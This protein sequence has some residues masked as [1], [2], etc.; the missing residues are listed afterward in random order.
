[1]KRKIRTKPESK[2][3]CIKCGEEFDEEPEEYLCK[4]CNGLLEVRVDFSN[5]KSAGKE[6]LK[7]RFE[8][9]S[10]NLWRY[11][12]LLPIES[13]KNIISLNEGGT[14]LIRACNIEHVLGLRKLYLK[15]EGLNPTGSFKDRG[16]TLG[17]TRAT[18]FGARAV[19]CASTGNT[20]ASLAAYAAKANLPCIVVVPS[21]KIAL[22]KL[23]Q[24]LLY[25][26][27]VIGIEGN[28]DLALKFVREICKSLGIYLLNSIN[29][30][31]L[32]GQKTLAFEIAEQLAWEAPDSI[33]LP[34]GNCGN[35]SAAWKG[36]KELYEL[37]L[38]E[39]LPKMIGVQAEGA[40]PVV[41]AFREGKSYAEPVAEPETVATAIRIGAPISAEK[42]LKAIKES[43]G[44]MLA[45][46]DEEIINAQKM[47]A[48]KEGIGA[49]PASATTIA[50][51]NEL[52]DRGVIK[53]DESIVCV[54]TGNAL[55]DP[56]IIIKHAERIEKC[57]N[58]EKLK[59]VIKGYI[60][61]KEVKAW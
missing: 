51:I 54:L 61:V 52:K 36:F 43:R 37:G 56:E 60:N 10:F 4:F 29:P 13:E 31:R 24:A 42:A 38:I 20:S 11:I 55:K 16:M 25:G 14:S 15:Y 32:E 59:D 7:K 45:V 19:A 46:S 34:V 28:F 35:I 5:L 9:R 40:A 6:E 21:D 41:K 17:I 33:I 2:L 23:S 18:E 39:K 12:E 49:E 27:K 22:G 50:A 44:Y 57:E 1:M 26:A 30:W 58:M 3:A 48:R 47:I 8:K 53:G